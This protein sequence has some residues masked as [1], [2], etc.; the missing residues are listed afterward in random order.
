MSLTLTFDKPAYNSGDKITA[1]YSGIV[2]NPGSPAGGDQ[3]LVVHGTAT[4]DGQP[5][6]VD[7]NLVVHGKPAVPAD[8]VTYNAPTAA[9]LTFAATADPKV[10]VATAS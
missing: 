4:L 2:L 5:V 3:T 9:G 1:T 7:E 10:W 8:T 6:S